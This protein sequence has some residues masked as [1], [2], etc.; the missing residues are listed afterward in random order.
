MI[1]KNS[2]N[3]LIQKS[4]SSG[5]TTPPTQIFTLSL[6]FIVGLYLVMLLKLWSY[7]HTLSQIRLLNPEPKFKRKFFFSF[8]AISSL[9]CGIYAVLFL[10]LWS[11]IQ[12]N[13]WCR[14]VALNRP[15]MLAKAARHPS[16][17]DFGPAAAA[18]NNAALRKAIFLFYYQIRIFRTFFFS[19]VFDSGFFFPT[20][21]FNSGVFFFFIYE[22]GFSELFFRI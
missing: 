5:P 21:Y 14:S 13:F 16:L 1:Q 10:K 7:I 22:S 11:Y 18:A 9:A 15:Q 2:N 8:L 4:I 19:F 17:A 20:F 12:V 6:V 3:P